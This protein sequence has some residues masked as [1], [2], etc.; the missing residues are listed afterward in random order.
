MGERASRRGRGA[1]H[2]GAT[3]N[4]RGW[5]AGGLLL[6]AAL[7]WTPCHA[8]ASDT[9]AA[10]QPALAEAAP[11]AAARVPLEHFARLPMFTGVSLSPDGARLAALVNRGEDTLLVTRDVD[12]GELRALMKT[13]NLKFRFRWA[14]WVGNERLLVSVLYPGRRGFTGTVEHRLFSVRA[15]DGEVKSMAR[16]GPVQQ[17]QD[18][19]IDWMRDDGRHVLLQLPMQEQLWETHWPAVFKLDVAT[20][21]YAL[22]HGPQRGVYDWVTDAQHRVRAAVRHE[23]G[24]P[25]ELIVRDPQG[26]PW[27]VLW[28]FR[29]DETEEIEPLGFGADPQEL[30]IRAPHE[31][32]TAIFS[33]RLD[34]PGT[35]RTLRLAH[36]LHDVEGSLIRSPLTREIVGVRG[37]GADDT[38]SELWDEEWHALA[39]AV[40]RGLP[41]RDNQ[42]LQISNDG[43]RYLLHSSGS[44]Q[45]GEYYVG[46]R[47]DG[48][49]M[50]LART[51]PDLKAEQ[52]AGKQ[53]VRIQARDGLPLAAYLTRARTGGTA[54]G[55]L[56]LLPH[57]GP[58]ARD[59]AS[60]DPWTELLANRGYTVL[61][62]NFRG[63]TGYGA[64]FQKA[65]FQRWGQEMQEDLEDA[66]QWAVSQ[67]VA[68]AR[69]ICIVGA[70]YGGYA[71]LMGVV[72]TPRLYRCAVSFAGVSNLSDLALHWTEFIG[73]KEGSRRVLGDWWKDRE[74]LRATS[75]ALQAQRIEVPV[76]LVHGSADRRVPVEQSRDM[77][78]ALASA[79]RSYR[80][81]EQEGG[82]HHFSRQA[83]HTEFLRE[84]EAFLQAHLAP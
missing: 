79:G 28:T 59:D 81:V 22:V 38:R 64:E 29:S 70:S 50:L 56:V 52:L 66:V 53:A 30:W 26:G 46:D 76:L 36:P 41:G 39:Q 57:G 44:R 9:P 24:K 67:G 3:V 75:P 5:R 74:R 63:S 15:A 40:D 17:I 13:D 11:P 78:K 12:G 37:N 69:R 27:R 48:Q 20:G 35:P 23:A 82:D 77:A 19:V 83:H 4:G 47:E 71:A 55:P 34:E 6:A 42:L 25:S 16:G 84:L 18:D 2:A 21:A 60:F 80:Y 10:Q 49:L 62:V 65:G 61:Q 7:A 1:G 73:G 32:R 45:P 51:Y 68:D 58:Y 14:R 43:Q 54:P 72:K 8:G 31:G 33:V